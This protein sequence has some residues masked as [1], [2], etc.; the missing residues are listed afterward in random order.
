MQTQHEEEEKGGYGANFA[1][2]EPWTIPS[3][4]IAQLGEHDLQA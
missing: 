4:N 1:Q 2:A 3:Q